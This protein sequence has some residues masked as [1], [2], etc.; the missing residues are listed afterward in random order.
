MHHRGVVNYIHWGIGAYGADQ[1]NGAPVFSSMAVDLTITNLLPL[2]AGRPVRL[3][4]EENPV[5]ALAEALRERPGFGMIKITPTHLSLLTPLLSQGEARAAAH[6]LVIGADFLMAEPTVFWQD[7][8][9]GVRLMNEYGPTETVVGCSAHVLEPGAHR[10]GPVPVGGPIQNLRFYVLDPWLN[11]VPE[12]IAGELYIGGVGVARG[13]LGRPGLSAEKF[14]PDPFAEAGA[15]MYRTGDRARWLEGGN[16]MIL[17]RTDGQVKVR[18]Y[19]VELGEIEAALRRH[20]AVDGA[21]VVAREDAPGDRRLVAYV[22]GPADA[23]S[24]REHLRAALPE[25]MVPSAF[26]RLDTLPKT[27]TGKVD[28]RTLP[29]PEY[30]APAES[31][32]PPDTPAEEALA[33]IWAEVLGV[34]RVGAADDF[35][36]LGGHSLLVMRLTARVQGAFGVHLPIRDVFAAPTL[37]AMAAEVERAVMAEILAMP[38]AAAE[39]LAELNPVTGE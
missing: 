36:E 18:G 17:G 23:A 37:R 15:R 1:G 24:L 13:Y 8:A 26:V 30:A 28:P 39:A 22:V 2:F 31:F 20:P 11:P 35:F 6:T 27:S 12:G 10:H 29:A 33:A 38:E 32:V 16:L 4:P 34:E 21:I 3:L 5:E 25:Y 19:R 9:P 7:H 14:V